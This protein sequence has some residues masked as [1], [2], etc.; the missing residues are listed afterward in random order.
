LRITRANCRR[1]FRSDLFSKRSAEAPSIHGASIDA[2]DLSPICKG[3]EQTRRD[4]GLEW[5][6]KGE[7]ATRFFLVCPFWAVNTAGR[8]SHAFDD[9]P[10]YHHPIDDIEPEI[11][12]RTSYREA[13]PHFVWVLP[14]AHKFVVAKQSGLEWRCN[15]SG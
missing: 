5:P 15:K 1:E 6:T 12:S 4:R 8:L 2:H 7:L 13:S 14:L 11:E 10:Y 3:C 9:I